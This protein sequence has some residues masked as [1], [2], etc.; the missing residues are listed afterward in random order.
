MRASTTSQAPREAPHAPINT[1]R[2]ALCAA[3]TSTGRPST[4]SSR[5]STPPRRRATPSAPPPGSRNGQRDSSST[6]RSQTPGNSVT[7]GH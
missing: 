3:R 6:R 5:S 7:A 4:W 1:V 2:A